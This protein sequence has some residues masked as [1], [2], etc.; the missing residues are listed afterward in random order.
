MLLAFTRLKLNC[1]LSVFA[2][3]SRKSARAKT[4]VG[5]LC[6]DDL[7]LQS[8]E[9]WRNDRAG[10]LRLKL[11]PVR[12]VEVVLLGADVEEGA[13]LLDRAADGAAKL[14]LR[15]V[16]RVPEGVVELSADGPADIKRFAVILVAAFLGDDVHESGIGAADLGR[17][18]GVN[19][20]KLAHHGLRKEERAILC[21]ALAAIQRIVEVGAIDRRAE[22]AG[23]L[24]ID[25]Q[26]GRVGS[27]CTPAASCPNWLKSRSRLGR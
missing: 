2:R 23:P 14:I 18:A 21:A 9:R 5:S 8:R 13:V 19:H 3:F 6:P 15:V 12:N 26:P 1:R 10:R 27:G 7:L 17:R 22:G 20:L 11:R 24:A 25:D 4:D 16:Q